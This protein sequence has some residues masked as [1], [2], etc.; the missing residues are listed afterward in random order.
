[1]S[2]DG[3]YGAK[4]IAYTFKDHFSV[5]SPLGPSQ[6]VLN[7]ENGMGIGIKFEATEIEIIRSITRGKSPGHDGL[8]IE[9][10]QHA[11]PHLPRL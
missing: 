11:V 2:V 10:L 1:M 4:D 6:S 9:H 5:G 7:V 8:S 3:V